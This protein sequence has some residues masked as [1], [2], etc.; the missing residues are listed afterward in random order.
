MPK[1]TDK[2]SALRTML[3]LCGFKE[4]A[5]GHFQKDTFGLTLSKERVPAKMRIKIQ[6]ISVRVELKR[7]APGSEWNKIDGAYLK[8]VI[9][10]P[11]GVRIGRKT[12]NVEEL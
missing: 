11:E 9:V 4:D 7:D 1:H 5:H 8:D 6:D 12:F 2:L 10:G 3:S